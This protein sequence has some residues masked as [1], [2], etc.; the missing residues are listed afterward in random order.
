[1]FNNLTSL[2]ITVVE[3]ALIVVTFIQTHKNLIPLLQKQLALEAPVSPH[4]SLQ[5]TMHGVGSQAA[6]PTTPSY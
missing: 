5:H 3:E 1:M 2:D 4:Q 6:G